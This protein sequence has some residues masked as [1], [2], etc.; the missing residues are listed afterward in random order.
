MPTK[1]TTPVKTLAKKSKSAPTLGDAFKLISNIKVNQIAY[2]LLLVAVFIIGY[3]FSRVQALEKA[4]AGTQVAAG[5]Q[6]AAAPAAPSA[7]NPADVLKKLSN[8]HFPVKGNANAKV[9]IVEFADFRCPFCE[10]FFTNTESQL[11]K[12]YVDTGK[13]AFYFRQ[14]AFLGAPSVVAA[15][16]AECANDQGKFWDYHDWLYKNQPPETDTSMYV[17]DKLTQAAGT[18]GMDTAKFQDCLSNNK[19]AALAQKDL[20]DGQAVGVSGTP[21]FYVN[22]QQIVGAVPYDNFK[23]AIEAELKK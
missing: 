1:R 20:S 3:L 2:V 11:I 18:L 22:G 16:A 5:A 9:K 7:P 15:N 23:T 10:Q 4:G 21:T 8:G 17:T 13:V 6:Q 19:D 12:D 14:Y